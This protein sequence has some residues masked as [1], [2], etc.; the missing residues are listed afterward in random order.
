MKFCKHSLAFVDLC[1]DTQLEKRKA[2]EM[3]LAVLF[4]QP[5]DCT[6][7]SIEPKIFVLRT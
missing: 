6:Q 5:S 1:V 2:I 7:Q 4:P 3:D